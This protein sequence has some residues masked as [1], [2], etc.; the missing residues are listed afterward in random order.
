MKPIPWMAATAAMGIVVG[1]LVGKN[2]GPGGERA[3]SKEERGRPGRDGESSRDRSRN[4]GS[5]NS[6]DEML[7]RFTGGRAIRSLSAADVTEI[8]RKN[9]NTDRNEDPVAAARRNY[10]L[11]L[12]LS[13]LPVG[14]LADASKL[15][16]EDEKLRSSEGY[17]VFNGWARRDWKAALEWADTAPGSSQ[18]VGYALSALASTDPG[19]AAKLMSERLESGN[20]SDLYLSGNNIGREYAKMGKDALMRYIET[21]PVSQ[22]S[23]TLSNAIRDI[24]EGE[25]EGL[26]DELYARREKGNDWSFSSSFSQF[27]K[28][29]PEKAR[30]WLAK[31][32]PGEE[33][34]KL[35]I[36]T[37]ATMLRGNQN[38]EGLEMIRSA[39]AQ[40][41]GKEKD[42]LRQTIMNTW[43]AGPEI[44]T[45]LADTLPAGVEMTAK[46]CASFG[47]SVS[48]GNGQNF[49]NVSK[50]IRSPTEKTQYLTN[51][52]DQAV[53][54]F[55]S[56][57]Y[58]RG[59]NDVDLRMI[60]TRLSSLNL[61]GDH[62]AQ[63][64]ESFA[65]LKEAAANARNKAN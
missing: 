57:S 54:R 18:Y 50:L 34:A 65:K 35:E 52:L 30:A 16:M 39:L 21:L 55:E 12:L 61:T 10:Q 17:K 13:Q 62:A 31:M 26:V 41:P 53:K 58:G 5:G 32:E 29:D 9:V 60:E 2:S 22:Q 37:G 23:N 47:S 46:D 15:V 51:C 44:Y 56:P 11:Q 6:G 48:V 20:F 40:A 43:Y 33:K 8:I 38:S 25:M 42:L 49:V 45:Q 28:A 14:V 36:S 4:G 19:Q 64:N 59:F 63:V 1:F 3:P 7:S 24:P 27:M